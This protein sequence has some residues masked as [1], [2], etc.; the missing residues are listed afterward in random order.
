MKPFIHALRWLLVWSVLPISSANAE[1][2]VQTPTNITLASEE[3]K[4]ATHSDGSG[5]YWDIFRYVYEPIGITVKTVSIPYE[6]AV[7]YTERGRADAW[8]GSYIDEKEFPLYPSWHFDIDVISVM[9]T[10]EKAD[11]F[12]GANSL[13]NQRVAW[14]KGYDFYPYFDKSIVAFEIENRKNLLRML[15]KGRIDY[16]LDARVDMDFAK[17]ELYQNDDSLIVRDL[18]TLKLYPAF[19]D[20]EKGKALS[21]IWDQRMEEIKDTKKMKGLFKQWGFDYP[22]H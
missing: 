19:S 16:Y 20:S 4:N 13:N 14:I 6:T 3:W 10:S 1:T 11:Q 22:F 18:L 9:F 17:N 21:R 2:A 8:V 5:L 12:Q 15:K 7:N